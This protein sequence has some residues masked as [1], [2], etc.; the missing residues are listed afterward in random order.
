MARSLLAL[1]QANRSRP[2]QAHM[3]VSFRVGP[4]AMAGRVLPCTKAP[5]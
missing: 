2:G 4:G 1:L 5:R 3:H